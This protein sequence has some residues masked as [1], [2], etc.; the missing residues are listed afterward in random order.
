MASNDFFYEQEL[1]DL[2]VMNKVLSHPAR[3]AIL[4]YVAS[5]ENCISGDISDF[6]PLGRTTVLQH[7]QEL[8]KIGFLKGEIHGAK[9]KYCVDKNKLEFFLTQINNFTNSIMPS[10]LRCCK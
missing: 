5:S 2:A 6:L 10:D 7:L 8:K 3:L 9:T 4:K 1:Q